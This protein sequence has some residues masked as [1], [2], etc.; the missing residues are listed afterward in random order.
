MTQVFKHQ[1]SVL[2]IL[3]NCSRLTHAKC[4]KQDFMTDIEMPMLHRY[5]PLAFAL[6]THDAK[7]AT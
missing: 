5:H 7:R 3:K 4:G 2:E 6:P 1:C